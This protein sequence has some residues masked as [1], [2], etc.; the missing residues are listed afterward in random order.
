M[1]FRSALLAKASGTAPGR[2]LGDG[3]GLLTAVFYAGYML[4]VK[5]LRVRLSSSSVMAGNSLVGAVA[6]LVL[7]RALDE[8]IFP[9]SLDGW[10]VL[11]GLAML[12]QVFGQGLIAWAIGHLSAR[13]SALGL[14]TQ[15]A[16][17][18]A[19]AWALF[20]ESFTTL[21]SIGIAL[22][23]VG[24]VVARLTDETAAPLAQ[25]RSGV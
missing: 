1:L 20:G 6:L 16:A 9:Q 7:A 23:A 22:V 10:A 4:T 21:Q 3:L 2:L 8:R 24:L 14:L 11:F 18:A 15:T 5:V 12:S 17:A 19:L 25:S 13:F